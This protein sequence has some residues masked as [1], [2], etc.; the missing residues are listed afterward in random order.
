MSRCA[1]CNGVENRTFP[2]AERCKHLFPSDD[3]T[4]QQRALDEIKL[5]A[6]SAMWVCDEVEC[7]SDEV[8]EE[9]A[10]SARQALDEL[11]GKIG[12]Q[13][14][15][16]RWRMRQIIEQAA[17]APEPCTPRLCAHAARIDEIVRQSALGD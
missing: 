17:N 11:E 5:M 14:A 7:S 6:S 15:D 10:D 1:I 4:A 16:L 8:R 13:A 9:S 3:V 12:D 2:D